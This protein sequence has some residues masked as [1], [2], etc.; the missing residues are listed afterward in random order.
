MGVAELSSG[1]FL[2]SKFQT[3]KQS[4]EQGPYYLNRIYISH[5]IDMQNIL[6]CGTQERIGER[7]I[8]MKQH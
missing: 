2:K 1:V 5:L 8:Q 7:L 3:N 4:C 6:V